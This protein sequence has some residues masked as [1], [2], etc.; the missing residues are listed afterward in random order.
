MPQGRLQWKGSTING[1]SLEKTE[2]DNLAIYTLSSPPLSL[3]PAH[4]IQ[5]TH[6]HTPVGS[7]S[8]A[9]L[10]ASEVARSELAGVTARTSVFSLVMNCITM[11]LIWN[12]MSGGWLPTGTFVRPGR[13]TKVK[14]NTVICVCVCVCVCVCACEYTEEKCWYCRPCYMY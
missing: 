2:R 7:T 12:S 3:S 8:L 5:N 13:S 11:S 4:L 10:R 6:T 1:S 9:I 14:F